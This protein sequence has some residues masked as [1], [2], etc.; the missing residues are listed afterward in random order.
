MSCYLES[1]AQPSFANEM[2][3]SALLDFKNLIVQDPNQIMS[4]WNGSI[5]FCNWVGVTCS[6]SDGRIILLNLASLG[7]AGSVAPSIGN[8]TYLTEINLAN[9]S[10]HGE[11]PQEMG[12]LLHLEKVLG[13]AYNRFGGELPSS[14]A[15]L[16]IWL[17]RL[18]IGGNVLRG[19]IPVGIENFLDLTLLGLERNNLS[20]SIPEVIGKFQKL[21]ENDDEVENE[22]YLEAEETCLSTRSTI[23]ECLVSVMRIGLLCSAT[24]PANRMAMNIVV[25]KL[26]AIRDSLIQEPYLKY[27]KPHTG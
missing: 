18:T 4:S 12:R 7:L 9:N 24:L 10:F 6:S 1:A 19:S 11:I 25:N 2:D 20:G 15:N 5:H 14:I 13:L 16:S 17:S 22:D 8:L 26:H 3:Y 21:E 23:E 27:R